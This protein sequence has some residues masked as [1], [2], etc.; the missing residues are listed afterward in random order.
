M[1]VNSLNFRLVYIR[2]F[3]RGCRSFIKDST[4]AR[5]IESGN[6]SYY[7]LLCVFLVFF[8]ILKVA[9]QFMTAFNMKYLL[10]IW[11]ILNILY[12]AIIVRVC[13]NACRMSFYILR[14]FH[15]YYKDRIILNLRRENAHAYNSNWFINCV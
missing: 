4:S 7:P 6:D 1:K 11:K 5:L 14:V 12:P 2:I 8:F 10:I 15:I 9:P 13:V 3:F